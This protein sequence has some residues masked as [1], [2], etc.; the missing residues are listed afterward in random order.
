MA[1]IDR[2]PSADALIAPKELKHGNY[3]QGAH[4]GKR[5]ES[6]SCIEEYARHNGHADLLRERIDGAT[7]D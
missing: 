2:R 3:E 5:D 4:V 6:D 7:G 1:P